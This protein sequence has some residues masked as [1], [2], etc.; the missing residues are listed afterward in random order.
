MKNIF[1]GIILP[2]LFGILVAILLNY[3][4]FA[5]KYPTPEVDELEVQKFVESVGVQIRIPCKIV[6]RSLT[7][8]K[9]EEGR[10]LSDIEFNR[11]SDDEKI[12]YEDG[13]LVKYS[14]WEKD[15]KKW[16]E[17]A[18]YGSGVLIYSA[19]LPEPL[20]SK[21]EGKDKG[22]YGETLVITNYHVAQPIIDKYSLGS[23]YEPI[24]VYEDKDIITTLFPP[25]ATVK[26][27]ARP[28]RQKYFVITDEDGKEATWLATRNTAGIKI[29]ESQHYEILA[30][31]VAYD[32][33]LDVAVL[34]IKNVFFQPYATFRQTP[35]QVGEKIWSRDAPLALA[36]S[37]NR[38][39]INQVGLDLGISEDGLGWMDQ[40]KTDIPSAP[41][42][43]GAGIFDVNGFLIAQHHGVLIHQL[44]DSWNYIEGGHLANPGDKIA[45]WLSWNGFSYIFEQKPYKT[46]QDFLMIHALPIEE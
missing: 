38:G 28:I 17:A 40:V 37:T 19:I 29:K 7:W 23:R 33:G 12:W 15:E 39:R 1:K 21:A 32:K 35:C 20:Q 9:F 22:I 3:P 36:F 30:T 46:Q 43:S 8:Y 16:T 45:E 31:V 24:N 27:G 4:V 18:I 25:K 26:P 11:L 6:Y 2:I 41:G 44:G 42:S 5:D 10:K 14:E 34:Q 13:Y